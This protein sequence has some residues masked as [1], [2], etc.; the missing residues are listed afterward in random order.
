MDYMERQWGIFGSVLVVVLLLTWIYMLP[1]ILGEEEIQ[2]VR[3]GLFSFFSIYVLWS[4][5][6]FLEVLQSSRKHF[7]L[8]PKILHF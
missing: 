6:I 5:R 2:G 7:F 3:L 8:S 1:S 4:S